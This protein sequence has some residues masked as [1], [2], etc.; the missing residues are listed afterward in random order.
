MTANLDV[1]LVAVALALLFGAA[2]WP[3]LWRK[4]KPL[5]CPVCMALWCSTATSL[6]GVALGSDFG[7]VTTWAL[8]FV[9]SALCYRFLFPPPLELP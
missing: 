4:K 9:L 1:A 3:A 7:S 5:G 8:G 2:P 6:G